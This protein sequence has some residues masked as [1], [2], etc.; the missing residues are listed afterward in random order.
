MQTSD[1]GVLEFVTHTFKLFR[2]RYEFVRDWGR[3]S[4]R[5]SEKES[6]A[7]NFRVATAAGLILLCYKVENS[8]W[9]R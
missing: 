1:K 4:V 8:R 9:D 6:F 5:I 3:E 7:S 2:F